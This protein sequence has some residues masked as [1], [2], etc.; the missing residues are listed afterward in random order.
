MD[1][2][3]TVTVLFRRWYVSLAAF[4]VAVG[5]A[6][7]IYT[8]I[9]TTYVSNAVLVLTTPITGGTLPTNPKHPNGLT[10]PL[11]NF[12]KGLNMSASIVVAALDA[13]EEAAK[14]GVTPAGDPIY[15]VNNGNPNPESL[16]ESPFV[17]ITGTSKSPIAARD[18]VVRV[19]A[20]ARQ[21]LDDRQKAL[22][23]PPKT[24]I[25]IDDMV[26][27]TAPKAQKGRKSRSAAVALAIGLVASL[28]AAFA[29]ESIAQ[30]AA[31]RRAAKEADGPALEAQRPVRA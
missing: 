4:T 1:F 25:T 27:P 3:G 12:D 10:N 28:C 31:G 16:T 29:A 30:A 9:P 24:Y 11:L 22:N 6:G 17:F 14:L 2:W 7:A 8:T 5:A 19:M 20:E 26:P 21:I 23:T 18:M 13:P 15:E